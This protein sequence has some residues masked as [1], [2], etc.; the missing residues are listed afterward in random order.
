M[1][2][3]WLRTVTVTAGGEGRVGGQMGLRTV[4][5]TGGGEGRAEDC[6]GHR[7]WGGKG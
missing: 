2:K 6:D 1:G 3:E 4:T 5:V 7:G